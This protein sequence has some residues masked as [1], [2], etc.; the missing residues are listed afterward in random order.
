M[1]AACK[2]R[3]GAALRQQRQDLDFPGGQARRV[4]ACRFVRTP[5]YGTHTPF[6]QAPAH[7]G[8]ERA[9]AERVEHRKGLAQRFLTTLGEC[10][11]PLVRGPD[12]L[13][14]LGGGPP[15]DCQQMPERL[16][17][18]LRYRGWDMDTRLP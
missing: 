5:W 17:N 8:S 10:Q 13:P 7:D 4:R 1:Q 12:A 9:C 14:I 2:L 18:V 3:V 15:S 6:A 16:L 11:R